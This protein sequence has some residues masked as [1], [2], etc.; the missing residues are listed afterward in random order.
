MALATFRRLIQDARAL[1]EPGFAEKLAADDAAR[2][3]VLRR[4]R[5]EI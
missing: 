4:G 5:Y 3:E 1:L 2:A